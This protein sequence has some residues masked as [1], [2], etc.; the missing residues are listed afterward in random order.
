MKTLIL[1]DE[2]GNL[3]FTMQGT[4]IK[5]NYSCIVTDIEENK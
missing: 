4:E 5:D 1:H 3:A 2:Q